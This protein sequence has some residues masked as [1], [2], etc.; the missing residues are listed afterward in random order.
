MALELTTGLMVAY[1]AIWTMAIV[2]IYIGSY[3][4]LKDTTSESMTKSDAWAFPL[5]GSVFLFG[6]YLLFKF[7]DKQLINMLLSY[8]FLFFGVV[9]LTR[10]LSDVFKRL[11]LSKSAAK[12]KRPLIEFTIPAIRFITDQQKVSIDSFDII[13]F[14]I[15]AGISYWYITTKHWI[16]NNIF[17]ITFSIQGI[18]LIGLHDYSVG[19]ILLCGLFLYDIFWVFGTDVMVTVAK[20]FEA[21]IKLLFPKDLF[22]EVYH[23]SML[24]LGDIVLPGIF[25]ALLLKFDKENSGGK[26]M[27]TTYFVSCLIAYAMGLATTIF[28]MHTFQAAQPALLYL[29]PFCIG[30]SLITAAAKGQVSKLIN[31]SS[32]TTSSSQSAKTNIIAQNQQ[33]AQVLSYFFNIPKVGIQMTIVDS[34]GNVQYSRGNSM[35]EKGFSLDLANVDS[36]KSIN[37]VNEICNAGK[38]Q[39]FDVSK[40]APMFFDSRSFTISR[41]GYVKLI[42]QGQTCTFNLTQCQGNVVLG[43]YNR[44][45]YTFQLSATPYEEIG[46][47][48]GAPTSQPV[49]TGTS[50]G[51]VSV[52]V[53]T[54]NSWTENGKYWSMFNGIIKNSGSVAVS[55]VV[56]TSKAVLKD[57]TTMWRMDTVQPGTYSMPSYLPPLLPGQSY[58]FSFIAEPTS[59]SLQFTVLKTN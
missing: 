32:K 1:A 55:T 54:V 41:Q 7:F 42:S 16:A 44:K 58:T 35:S 30:S 15:S 53:E 12:K 8:Y 52:T 34:Y 4:S 50:G 51:G 27:K 46:S 14:V 25:I 43:Y 26:Q 28:V 18:S 11:F 21:P 38:Y 13:A 22:A 10:I 9:A 6:L 49:T 17:G 20:S 2:P 37:S 19:V 5:F 31:F 3:M 33:C 39:P 59:T 23:F 57:S 45:L 24:G 56:V 29:V 48:C 47:Y 40:A 36:F